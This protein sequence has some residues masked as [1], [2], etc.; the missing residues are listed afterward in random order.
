MNSTPT[1]ELRNTCAGFS[2]LHTF[3]LQ[4]RI[5]ACDDSYSQDNHLELVFG[6]VD[7]RGPD[8]N[9]VK[10]KQIIWHNDSEL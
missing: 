6:N 10:D 5:L 3:K 4:A 9:R 8:V 2:Q 1:E 7:G